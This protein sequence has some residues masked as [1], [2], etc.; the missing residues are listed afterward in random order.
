M[1]GII[2][3]SVEMTE[4]GVLNV[5][6]EFPAFPSAHM[7]PQTRLILPPL[8]KTRTTHSATQREFLLH[9]LSFCIKHGK[10]LLC[11]L[12]FDPFS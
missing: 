3:S 11:L 5:N 12:P 7:S 1:T 6:T 8:R 2:F 9:F 4:D 10:F